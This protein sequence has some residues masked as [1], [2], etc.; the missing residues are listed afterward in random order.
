M[1]FKAFFM[2]LCTFGLLYFCTATAV[3][4]ALSWYETAG[5]LAA[6]MAPSD[7]SPS[8]A[9]NSGEVPSGGT[10]GETV[11]QEVAPEE[12][13]G[14][15]QRNR[16][17]NNDTSTREEA[18]RLRQT[19]RAIVAEYEKIGAGELAQQ[20]ID[21]SQIVQIAENPTGWREMLFL[22]AGLVSL[23]AAL[24]ITKVLASMLKVEI[25]QLLWIPIAGCIAL[26]VGLF[27]AIRAAK[28]QKVAIATGVALSAAGVI[29]FVDPIR[30]AFFGI[31]ADVF[32][33]FTAWYVPLVV[34]AF[35]I[36]GLLIVFF[37]LC[38]SYFFF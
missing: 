29:S 5:A 4:A 19:M 36:V 27:M 28:K 1:T 30:H 11:D 31:V 3:F 25:A 24:F 23:L 12:H 15:F 35:G 22:L 14:H 20:C 10:N 2:R 17:R 34:V 6:G 21:A 13:S 38:I 16:R 33:I 32:V 9:G 26:L 7:P 8:Q 18:E 37:F